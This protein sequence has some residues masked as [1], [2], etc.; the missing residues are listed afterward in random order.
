MTKNEIQALFKKHYIQMYRY[1]ESILYDEDESKDAVCEVFAR[2]LDKNIS[3]NE[4]TLEAFLMTAVRNKCLNAIERKNVRQRFLRLISEETDI[5]VYSLDEEKIRMKELMEYISKHLTPLG[6]NIFKL[7]FLKDLT[8]QEVAEY[9]G[10]S[11]Q[12]VHNHLRQAISKIK[13]FFN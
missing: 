10:I 3:L 11:R 12:T 8:C 5:A 4:T 7:R 1:A 2:L 9:L 13:L 6:I